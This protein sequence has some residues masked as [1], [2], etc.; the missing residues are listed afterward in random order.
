M[1]PAF[2]R[3]MPRIHVSVA[4]RP[5]RGTRSNNYRHNSNGARGNK[6]GGSQNQRGNVPSLTSPDSSNYNGLDRKKAW[7]ELDDL[8]Y[9]G[10]DWVKKS[11]EDV[12]DYL[13]I[14]KQGT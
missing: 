14:Q 7:E 3:H 4:L 10:G 11:E 9:Q 13:P 1:L 12:F 2:F 5:A 6:L 8:E